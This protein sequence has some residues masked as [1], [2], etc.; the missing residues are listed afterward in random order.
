M[1][2]SLGWL[3]FPDPLPLFSSLSFVLLH[4]KEIGLSFWVSGV[5]CQHSKVFF[6]E[7]ASHEDDLLTYL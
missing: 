3:S 2:P 7:V 4:F 6:V 5:L 1:T